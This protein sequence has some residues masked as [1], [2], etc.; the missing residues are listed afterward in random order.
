MPSWRMVLLAIAEAWEKR[1]G[2]VRRQ[3]SQ[4]V[5]ALGASAR[6]Q[7]ST[8][9][10]REQLVIK[11]TESLRASFDPVNGGWG[12]APK[13]PAASLIELLLSRGER[14]MSLAALRAM[15]QGG[16]YDHVGG[17][18]ARYAV[19]AT[20][21]VPHFEKMLYDNA[22][23]A[24]AYLHGWQVSGEER[25]REVCC[26]TLD[27]TIREMRGSEGGFCSSLDAD[28]E[29]VE[30]KFY[31]WTLDELRSVLGD[32]YEEA[33]AH[34][35]PREFE[36]G[37]FVLEGR[38]PGPPRLDEIRSALFE[39]RAGRVRPGLDDKRL[40]SWNAL[41]ISALADAGAVLGSAD[42]VEAA[43]ACASFLLSERRDPSGRLLRTAHIPAYLDDHA[44]LLEALLTLYETTFDPRWYSEAVS[45]ADTLIAR[46]SDP[47]RGG[48]YT[49]ADDLEQLPARRKDLEDSPIPSGNSAA[50]FGL[51]R[52]SL[53]SGEGK[54]ERHAL[55]VLR[56]L[57]QVAVRHPHAFGHLLR[58]AD[59]YLA[60][61]REVAIVGPPGEAD[62]LV[63]VV[64]GAFRPHL[65]L[66]GGPGDGVPLLE[67]REPVDGRAAAYVCE[68][69]VCQAPVTSP[70]ELSAAL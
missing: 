54:Y 33:M 23:L 44:Y 26:E 3:G 12:G 31:V 17:G 6:I 49:T 47:E 11:A 46:F 21:T 65:V 59:F 34:F 29:G 22:L 7:P 56:L 57:F 13:F 64:R 52:L 63:R 5:E 8:E 66:A 1:R 50:A 61:V 43:V 25:F 35:G 36:H 53:L 24:R 16:I 48:F 18:F 28:S 20:W 41:M 40:T 38:G 58:A 69:F 62:A 14:E 10:I 9:P 42:Y 39:A 67:G 32:L 45:V 2:E 15:A 19:D 4:L 68:H 30:G 55:G 60:P 27:W 37:T 70:E 51:L